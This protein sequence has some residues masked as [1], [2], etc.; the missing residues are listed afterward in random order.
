MT[1]RLRPR[2]HDRFEQEKTN[3]KE[4]KDSAFSEIILDGLEIRIWIQIQIQ[5]Q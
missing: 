3:R 4:Q 2:F 5:I 1:L